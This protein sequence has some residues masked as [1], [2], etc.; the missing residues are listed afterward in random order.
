ME[1]WNK[2]HSAKGDVKMDDFHPAAIG[3]VW[4]TGVSMTNQEVFDALTATESIYLDPFRMRDLTT[5]AI[6]ESLRKRDEESF[7]RLTEFLKK[8]DQEIQR[9]HG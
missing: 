2:A 5:G 3:Q 6:D 8:I 4:N 9:K 7:Y 1:V